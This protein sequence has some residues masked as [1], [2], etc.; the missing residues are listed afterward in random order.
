MC[1]ENVNANATDNAQ[2]RPVASAEAKIDLGDS[3]ILP[4]HPF[5]VKSSRLLNL[6][7]ENDNLT[8]KI[9]RL[10]AFLEGEQCEKI[11]GA[12]QVELMRSQLK[13]MENYKFF[14]SCRIADLALSDLEPTEENKVGE[15]G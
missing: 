13:A 8:E 9:Y 2:M 6:A 5:L 1:N 12:K 10:K 3:P 11:A 4:Y 7:R 15:N 14:L